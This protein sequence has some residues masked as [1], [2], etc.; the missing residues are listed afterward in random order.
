[1]LVCASVDLAAGHYSVCG[2]CI[3]REST[4]TRSEEGFWLRNP[5]IEISFADAV[6]SMVEMDLTWLRWPDWQA[7]SLPTISDL[8][9]LP[10]FAFFIAVVRFCLSKLIFEVGSLLSFRAFYCFFSF[11]YESVSMNWRY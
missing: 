3:E 1:M 10:V 9:V 5:E 7:E 6:V 11:S 2:T 8:R 4:L